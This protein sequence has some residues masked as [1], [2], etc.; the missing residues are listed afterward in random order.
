[1][2]VSSLPPVGISR[3]RSSMRKT[4]VS[5]RMICRWR[6]FSLSTLRVYFEPF[7][8]ILPAGRTDLSS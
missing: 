2:L 8:W 5:L 1:M 4:A 3:S 6:S 7:S